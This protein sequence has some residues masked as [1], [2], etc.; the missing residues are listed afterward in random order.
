MLITILSVWLFSIIVLHCIAADPIMGPCTPSGLFWYVN[1]CIYLF[2]LF[3]VW[4]DKDWYLLVCPLGEDML[5]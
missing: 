5:D 2:I 4:E 1:S 3:F